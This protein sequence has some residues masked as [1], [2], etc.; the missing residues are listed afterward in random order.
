MGHPCR[1]HWC[2]HFLGFS[3]VRDEA[4]LTSQNPYTTLSLLHTSTDSKEEK[5]LKNPLL[6][7]E[8][9]AECCRDIC[10]KGM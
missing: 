10:Y 4:L 5:G 7:Q 1:M 8:E 3:Q 6:R 2:L 9:C